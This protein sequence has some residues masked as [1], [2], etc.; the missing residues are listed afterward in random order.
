MNTLPPGGVIPELF[1]G[2]FDDAAVFPPG[3][4]P[5]VDA[6]PAHRLH[7][8]AWYAE[9][10]GPRQSGAGRQGGVAPAGAPNPETPP[11][12]KRAPGGAGA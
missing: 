1:H 10:V 7:R 6:V 8:A 9:A 4:L 12:Q 3:N 2:L 11:A 5:I